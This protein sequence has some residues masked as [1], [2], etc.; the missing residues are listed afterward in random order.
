MPAEF[1]DR[2]VPQ[3]ECMRINQRLFVP[4]Q[5][6]RQG[7]ANAEDF[8]RR[9]ILFCKQALHQLR[10]HGGIGVRPL[11][12]TLFPLEPHQLAGQIGK[13]CADMVLCDLQTDRIT[14]VP[15]RRK[16][17]RLAA[18]GRFKGT[19]LLH[20]P[21]FHQLFDVLKHGRPTVADFGGQFRLGNAVAVKNTAHGSD[22][23]DLLYIAVA[24][25]AFRHHLAPPRTGL[26]LQEDL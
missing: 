19:D 12:G 23:V 10:Q 4:V 24:G 2:H 8:F 1:L 13:H 9:T 22:S 17:F 26:H 3:S 15:H 6:T 16:G 21:H 18:A 14:G 20:Q 7:N 5:N 25:S 11:K